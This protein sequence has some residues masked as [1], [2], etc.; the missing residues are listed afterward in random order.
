MII[1][2]IIILSHTSIE[3]IVLYCRRA[4]AEV[5][6]LH[7]SQGA[8]PKGVKENKELKDVDS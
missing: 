1:I 8:T 6:M 2:I 4:S 3:Y 7:C 5:A